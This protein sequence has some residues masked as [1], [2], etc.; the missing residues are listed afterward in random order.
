ML[1]FTYSALLILGILIFVISIPEK[2]VDRRSNSSVTKKAIIKT[3]MVDKDEI[4]NYYDIYKQSSLN[5]PSLHNHTI[6]HAVIKVDG[7]FLG[8]QIKI[9]LWN[10]VV[11]VPVEISVSQI[12]IGTSDGDD[13][14]IIEAGWLVSQHLY[15]DDQTRFFIL[16][17]TDNCKSGCFVLRC[18]G[19]VHI[20]SDVALGCN[21]TDMSTF[22]GDQKDASFGIHKDQNSG[23]WWVILQGIPVGYYPNSLFTQLS[24]KA[25]RI[26][27]GGEIFNTRSKGRHTITQMGSGHFPSEGGFEISSFFNHVQ[28]IDENNET[29]DLE[30]V[31]LI[32]SNPNCY[33]LKIDD[34]HANGYSFYYGG[35]GY[36]DNCE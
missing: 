34:E 36:T 6:Q 16:W 1:K 7:N 10:P 24:K 32:I 5:H 8:S 28:V 26:D 29:K 14:N 9:N 22:K 30:D 11:E 12:W 20:S 33:D 19:F 4:I 25:T 27:F 21:F 31:K 3:I 23:N 35:P 18:D 2:L 13:A 15:G 17:T